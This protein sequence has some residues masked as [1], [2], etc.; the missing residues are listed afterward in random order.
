MINLNNK[1]IAHRGVFNNINIPENSLSAFKKSI[2]MNLPI[3][4]DVMLTSDNK[5][6][7][8]HDFNLS[9][10]TGEDLFLEY[11]TYEEINKINLLDTKEKIPTLKEVLELVNGKVFLD[12]EIKCTK[13]YKKICQEVASLLDDYKYDFFVQS[14]NPKIIKWFNKNRRNYLTGLIIMNKNF[15]ITKLLV[16]YCKPNILVVYKKNIKNE[17][18]QKLRK[19][20]LLITWTIKKESELEKYNNYADCYMCNNIQYYKNKN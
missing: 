17:F 13:N 3:E 14:F 5:L 11:V 2:D 20:Y 7:V 9:R 19:K 4:L 1:L 12:I 16:N 8:F 18:F 15:F 6:V 10:M